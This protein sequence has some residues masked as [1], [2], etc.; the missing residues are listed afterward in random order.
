MAGLGSRITSEQTTRKNADTYLSSEI[1]SKV[2][3][4]DEVDHTISGSSSLSVVKISKDNY[5]QLVATA[6][7]GDEKLS[8]NVL[9][10][11]DSSYI[12]AYGQQIKNLSAATEL[13]D[14]VTLGQLLSGLGTKQDTVGD[15]G[16]IRLSA[17]SAV[18]KSAISSALSVLD[19]DPLSSLTTDSMLSDVIGAVV[20]MRNALSAL[21]DILS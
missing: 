12:D 1:S 2:W 20:T 11:V 21:R 8:T 15:L 10:V 5:E 16:S 3:I 6:Q 19:E 7:P 17:E 9:Y 18:P 13:S 14:A 4:A